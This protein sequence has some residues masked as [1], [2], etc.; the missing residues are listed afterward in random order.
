MIAGLSLLAG[1]CSRKYTWPVNGS[2]SGTVRLVFYTDVHARTEW[3][4]PKAMALAADTINAQKA[5]LVIAGG[6][7]ITD[8]FDSSPAKVAP[9]WNAYM[10]MQHAIHADV[11][12]TIGNHDLVGA[13]P[14]DGSEA[15]INPRSVYLNQ[16]GLH[17]TYYAFDAVGYHFVVL[18]SIEITGD[19]YKYRGFIWPE[20][21]E[22]LKRD[23]AAVRQG[24]P[25]V[26]VTHIPLLTSFYAA[27]KGATY[28]APQNRVVVNNHEVLKILQN[29]NVIL[30]MQGHLHVK[31]LIAWQRTSFIVGGAVSG[32]WWRGPYFGSEEGFNSITL[33]GS[34]V[35][36]EYIDYGWT[37]RRP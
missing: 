32:K 25:I 21:L 14:H 27:T 12:P 20:Q 6:D 29:H 18:D 5:D 16:T 11:Y 31:E 36:W 13:D 7:L 28:S 35:H 34:R 10:E 3:E 4:T 9:R 8:G 15:V 1:G 19:R 22:W 37:A 2:D 26:V 30:V 33:G 23:L 17:Q 24:T